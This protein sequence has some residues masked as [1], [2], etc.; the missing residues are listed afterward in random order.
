[1]FCLK[2]ENKK[3]T[4]WAT[5]GKS[6][7]P[8]GSTLRWQRRNLSSSGTG[9]I[10]TEPQPPVSSCKSLESQARPQPG[11]L[12]RA[13]RTDEGPLRQPQD[14]Q[15]SLP[16]DKVR[17]SRA[18]RHLAPESHPPPTPCPL[19]PWHSPHFPAPSTPGCLVPLA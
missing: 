17:P 4:L 14:T 2:K 16:R 13:P 15:V 7:W 5:G 6:H 12:L 8:A 11:S 9:G 19:L 3:S 18:T 10:C 1:M